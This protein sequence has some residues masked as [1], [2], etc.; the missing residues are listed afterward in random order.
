MSG[1]AGPDAFPGG[2]PPAGMTAGTTAAWRTFYRH[3]WATYGIAPAEYR[4]LYLAQLGRCYICRKARGVHP[5]DPKAR[6]GARRLGVDHNHA[7]GNR[8]EAVRGLLCTGGDRTCNRIIGWLTAEGLDRA[9]DLLRTAPAQSV[10]ARLAEPHT[11]EE[12]SGMVVDR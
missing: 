11:D 12:I 7:L 6:P 8:R 1:L 2:T 9:A 5:D 4:A 10:L 3:V